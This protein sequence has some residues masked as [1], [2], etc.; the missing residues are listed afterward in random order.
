MW[1]FVFRSEIV[2]IHNLCFKKGSCMRIIAVA[3]FFVSVVSA[4]AGFIGIATNG[5][6][7]GRT[8]G[9]GDGSVGLRAGARI[10]DGLISIENYSNSQLTAGLRLKYLFTTFKG[11]FFSLG[12]GPAIGV[13][14]R[15]ATPRGWNLAASAQVQPEF[16]LNEKIK[17]FLNSEVIRGFYTDFVELEADPLGYMSMGVKIGFNGK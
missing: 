11:P 2:I 3:A 8:F 17:L 5:I 15:F 10:I 4:H 16:T 6:E 13:D 7:V 12:I 1:L 9:P 14:R